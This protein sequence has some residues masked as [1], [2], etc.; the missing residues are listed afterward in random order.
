MAYELT[1]QR[2]GKLTVIANVGRRRGSVLWR[3]VCDCGGTRDATSNKLVSGRTVACG[4]SHG[5]PTHGHTRARRSSPTYSSWSAMIARCTYPS[6]P[7]YEHYKKRGI[8]ICDRW[9]EFENFLSDVGERP[10]LLHTLDRVD[11]NASYKPG[12]VRWA[13]RKEQ[14]N[15]RMT[16]VWFE[17][18]GQQ[19]TFQQLVEK[20]GLPKEFLRHRLLRAKWSLDKALSYPKIQGQRIKTELPLPMA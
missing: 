3:C 6:N 17:Y 19:L 5:S 14:A 2:F 11:N 7:A 9:R 10:S 12:N 13:T 15:N 8:T 4:C 16:N 18:D 20:T 1:G